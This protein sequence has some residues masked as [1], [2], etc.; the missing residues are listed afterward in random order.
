MRIAGARGAGALEGAETRSQ[1]GALDRPYRLVIDGGQGG[2]RRERPGL[3]EGGLE[4]AIAGQVVSR[5]DVD[6]E[7]IEKTPVGRIIG[8][9]AAAIRGKQRV[10]RADAEIG[11]A[12][13]AGRGACEAE[14]RE[15]ADPLIALPSPQRI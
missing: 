3:R 9:R 2:D 4:L 6:Q 10:H 7:R 12:F 14:G 11:G 13:G 15:I 8:A 5:E 1:R